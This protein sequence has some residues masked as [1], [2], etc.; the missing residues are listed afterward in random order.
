MRGLIGLCADLGGKILVHGSPAQRNVPSDENP[1]DA[2]LRARDSFAA[3]A[4]DAESAGVTYCIEPLSREECNFI[5]TV[6]D[7]VTMV[8]TV[9]SPA[10][11][12]MIDHR[13]ASLAEKES[14]P[15]LLDRWLPTGL[16]RHIHVNDT[17]RRAPGQGD[18]RFTPVFAALR[19]NDYTGIISVE[20]FNYLPSGPATAAVAMGYIRGILEALS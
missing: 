6:A 2:W 14:V 17:N 16:I 9:G 4:G 13:A 12:T 20:P 5:N 15:Q 7:A 19:R 3:V 18:N 1:Q 11:K 8:E 10:I